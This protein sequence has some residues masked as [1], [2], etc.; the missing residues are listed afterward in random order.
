MRSFVQETTSSDRKTIRPAAGLRCAMRRQSW[1]TPFNLNRDIPV[2]ELGAG[3]RGK[4]RNHGVPI[5]GHRVGADFAG[6]KFFIEFVSL[7][8]QRVSAVLSQP[9]LIRLA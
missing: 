2:V 3:D 6:L 9:G 1:S 5:V 8:F 4:C 7:L